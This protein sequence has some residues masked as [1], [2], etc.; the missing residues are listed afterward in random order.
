MF[1][2]LS[3]NLN[4]I[5]RKLRGSAVMSE[6]NTRDALREIRMALLEA[7][8]SYKV[9]RDFTNSCL[10][11]ALGQEVLRSVAPGQQIVKIVHDELVA[12]MGPVDHAFRFASHG[13]TVIM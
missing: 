7:D 4:D 6:T 8:V 5:F 1:D 2:S 3:K 13:P 12:L 11:R 9:V 10:Q